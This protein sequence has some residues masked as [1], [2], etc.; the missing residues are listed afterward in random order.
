MLVLCY[1]T[2]RKEQFNENC[3]KV[4]RQDRK[5]RKGDGEG[6]QAV[7]GLETSHQQEGGGISSP[8]SRRSS[9]SRGWLWRR[10]R[11]RG[12]AGSL[13]PRQSGTFQERGAVR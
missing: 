9:R 10:D 7:P 13:A 2:D 12:G 8:S 3:Q 1:N 4:P 6:H 11:R 5:R